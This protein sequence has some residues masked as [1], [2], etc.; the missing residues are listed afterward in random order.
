MGM[1]GLDALS[2]LGQHHKD[3]VTQVLR[4]RDDKYFYFFA[5]GGINI[6][7]TVLT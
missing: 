1:L 3:L 2:Y 7:S 5:I 4:P 6:A